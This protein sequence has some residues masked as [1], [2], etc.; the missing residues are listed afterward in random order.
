MIVYPAIDLRGGCVVRL[1]QGDFDAETRYDGTPLALARRHVA[2]GARMLHVVDLDA[3]RSGVATNRDAIAAIAA[4]AGVPVQAG[5]G[6]RQA[7]D[8]EHYLAAGVARVVIGSVAV[9]DPARVVEWIERHGTE[10]ICLALDVRAD[11]DGIY[12]PAVAGWT[13]TPAITLAALLAHYEARAPG[14]A[15]LCT[16]IARDGMLGGPNL[17]LYAAI[18]A[19]HPSLALIASGGLRDADDVRALRALGLAGAVA[20]RALLERPALLPEMLAC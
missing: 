20:G 4:G 10:R 11:A 18:R 14:V 2:A 1:R 8:V 6:V 15:V 3:A 7:S 12:R 19:S 17:A 5:G 16:D 9:R 13:E